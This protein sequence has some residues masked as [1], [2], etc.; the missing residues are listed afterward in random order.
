MSIC[1]I[2]LLP[3]R[4]NEFGLWSSPSVCLKCHRQ[5]EWHHRWF[6]IHHCS[7]ESFYEYGDYFQ[8][9]LYRFKGLGDIALA[10]YFLHYHRRYISWRYHGYRL[11]YAPSH[12][13]H[14]LKR[15]FHHLEMIFERIA[16]KKIHL[17]HKRYPYRQA[18]QNL[19][20]RDQVQQVI[21]LSIKP[22]ADKYLLVD[23]V[24]TTGETMRHLIHL[25]HQQQIHN[26]KILVL[27]IKSKTYLHYKAN[28]T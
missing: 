27:A 19:S 25:L 9:Q 14:I 7:V 3:L 5:W 18:E 6:K 28:Q 8:Q 20:T 10:P 15:G 1:K 17:F 13:D 11:V 16:L 24:M 2:C 22:E 23:D 4:E 21:T 26:I 12:D